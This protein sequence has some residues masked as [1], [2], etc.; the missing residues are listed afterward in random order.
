MRK[1]NKE[2]TIR[3]VSLMSAILGIVFLLFISANIAISFHNSILHIKELEIRLQQTQE[4]QKQLLENLRV[5]QQEQ[6]QLKLIEQ[7]RTEAEQKRARSV[8]NIQSR[9]FNRYTDISANKDLSI[10]DMDKI[11]DTWD[12]HIKGGTR[13]KGH[14]AAFIE[15]S[16]VSGLNP[17]IILAHAAAESSWGNSVIAIEKNNFF[18]INCVDSNPNAGFDMGDDID[19]GIVSGAIWIKKNFYSNGYTSLQSMLDAN[20]AS[21]KS[22][23]GRIVSIANASARLLEI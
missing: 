13:F 2:A 16:K 5:V 14:G 15:A 6:E 8:S 22:W 20:Y 11:I 18:G 4:T 17:I 3:A 21:D 23:A 9:G 1:L 10:E 7:E 12:N 19:S